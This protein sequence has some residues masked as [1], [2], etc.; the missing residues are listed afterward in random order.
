MGCSNSSRILPMSELQSGALPPDIIFLD[1]S[2]F[3]EAVDVAAR[4]FAGT[5]TTN[6]DLSLDWCLGPHLRG[7]FDDPRRLEFMQWLHRM[8]LL[9]QLKYDGGFAL[10]GKKTDGS[11]GAV[12]MS[13]PFIT[14]KPPSDFRSG[15]RYMKNY[16]ELGEPPFSRKPMSLNVGKGISKRL[17]AVTK[18]M[19]AA[20]KKHAAGPHFYIAVMAVD[21]GAQGQGLCGKL[22]RAVSRFADELNAPCYLE[23][24]GSRNASIYER[25]GY[26]DKEK[27]TVTCKNDPDG[28]AP[29]QD[30]FAMVRPP[31]TG[32][33][34]SRE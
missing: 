14:V 31:K 10:G 9:F 26:K 23:T 3:E 22:M 12:L 17:N 15:L 32:A 34:P 1:D 28:S 33:A 30:F 29:L 4:S 7:R 13:T 16:S 25:F 6:P 21:P 8:L 27:Y 20:H 2:H 5:A 18:V 19:A 11:L 24:T